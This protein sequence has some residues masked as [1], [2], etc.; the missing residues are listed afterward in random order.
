[1]FYG[2]GVQSGPRCHVWCAQH[3]CHMWC[4][5]F[6]RN[7][8]CLRTTWGRCPLPGNHESMASPVTGHILGATESHIQCLILLNAEICMREEA[9]AIEVWSLNFPRSLQTV[10]QGHDG[11]SIDWFWKS[12]WLIHKIAL[13]TR[14][15]LL[16][17][18]SQNDLKVPRKQIDVT[19]ISIS[20]E[21]QISKSVYWTNATPLPQVN[22]RDS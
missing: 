9:E 15:A 12:C 17:V 4:A 5:R 6:A 14:I 13:C 19:N 22:C 10:W 1:M 16:P 21:N 8:Q 7:L 3:R 18:R 2:N 20:T 11:Q